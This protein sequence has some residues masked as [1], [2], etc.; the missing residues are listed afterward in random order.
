MNRRHFLRTSLV[1]PATLVASR[2]WAPLPAQAVE[3]VRRA[4]SS[5][6]LALGLAAYSFRDSMTVASHPRAKAPNPA[7]QMDMF[8]FI[9]FCAAHG[10]RGAELTSYYFP[11]D[12]DRDYFIRIRRH[13][14]LQGV[15]ISGSA[16]G[17]TFTLTAGE[18]RDQEIAHVKRWTEYTSLMGASHVRVFAGTLTG[19][20]TL[21]EAKRL[22]VEALEEC[23][24]Y[25]GQHGVFLGIENHGGIV[26][27][28]S[29]LLDIVK[30]VRSPW[31]GI[32]LD[33]G[34]FH[35]DDPYADLARCA[36]YAVNVQLK[37]EIAPR[38]KPGGRADFKRLIQILKDA[39]YSGYVTLEYESKPDPWDAVPKLLDELREIL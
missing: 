17:N 5:V 29:D 8:G 16:V 11:P 2:L 12:A 38:N 7:K 35:T 9:D 36:P 3:P 28:P 13:A 1:A 15:E 20:Q 32:N 27:E 26:A 19:K 18:K 24:S 22:C 39:G 30:A 4:G 33:T 34:N 31:V 21:P 37:E 6:R 25:A 10:C 14:F 23:G